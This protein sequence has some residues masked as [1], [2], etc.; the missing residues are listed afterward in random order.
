M[1]IEDSNPGEVN[2]RSPIITFVP[3]VKK[4]SNLNLYIM[5]IYKTSLRQ[6][7]SNL[8]IIFYFY[9]FIFIFIFIINLFKKELSPLLVIVPTLSFL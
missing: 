8:L 9:L 1:I 2:V 3:N 6:G 7:T 4:N 5:P